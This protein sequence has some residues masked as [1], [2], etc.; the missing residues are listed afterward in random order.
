MLYNGQIKKIIMRISANNLK[1]VNDNTTT[2]PD[3]SVTHNAC[4]TKIKKREVPLSFGS[5]EVNII[6][7]VY[8]PKCSEPEVPVNKVATEE[9]EVVDIE[10]VETISSP[11][12]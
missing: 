3:N 12:K 6:Y 2:H 1:W 8:C 4:G 9:L 5:G 10:E 7:Y 11:E